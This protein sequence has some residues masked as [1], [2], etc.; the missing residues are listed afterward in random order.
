MD[1][2]P[3]LTREEAIDRYWAEL[4]AGASSPIVTGIDEET[5]A[6]IRELF[7]LS[8]AP[9]PAAAH[10]RMQRTIDQ[11]VEKRRALLSR[12]DGTM[13]IDL[14]LDGRAT[15]VPAPG[16][17]RVLP[18]WPVVARAGRHSRAALAFFGAVLLVVAMAAALFIAFRPD[19][20]DLLVI[21]PAS[22]VASPSASSVF[23]PPDAIVDGANSGVWL[24]RYFQWWISLFT[25]E[26]DT[27]DDDAGAHCGLGQHGPVFFLNGAV[28]GADRSCAVPADVIIYVPV[29]AGECSTGEAP[30]Y[31]GEDEESLRACAA[32]SIDRGI[33]EIFPQMY[34]RVDG[35]SVELAPYRTQTPLYTLVWPADNTAG[36][37]PGVAQ[38]VGDGYGVM[39]GPLSPGEHVVEMVFANG[40]RYPPRVTY[41]LT[42]VTG[43]VLPTST[44][45][46]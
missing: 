31:F 17:G 21:A 18:R 3:L 16:W 19:D 34:L 8:H 25:A 5:A 29:N 4:T 33:A 1:G 28:A 36:A 2:E 12:R 45:T 15:A 14:V 43:E 38:S 20:G 37:R 42:V 44:P 13:E 41:H 22:P 7:R 46:T 39:V 32:E 10:A 6:G 27:Y 40:D 11:E 35:E 26:T 9:P 23:L 24:S 30:P